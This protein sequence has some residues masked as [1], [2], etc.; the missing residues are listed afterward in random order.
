MIISSDLTNNFNFTSVT[1]RGMFKNFTYNENSAGGSPLF[2]LEL[3]YFNQESEIKIQKHEKK[4]T[5]T[6]LYKT[7][8]DG[9]I[10]SPKDLIILFEWLKIV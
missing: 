1:S 6:W 8:F 9:T 10:N 7:I 2:T 3:K 5:S 4:N